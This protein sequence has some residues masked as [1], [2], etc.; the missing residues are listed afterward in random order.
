MWFCSRFALQYTISIA[1]LP[2]CLRC[3]QLV[4]QP[5]VSGMSGS[6]L[7]TT[8]SSKYLP[9]P[10]EVSLATLLPWV[11]NDLKVW[12]STALSLE[13]TTA[14]CLCVGGCGV[15]LGHLFGVGVGPAGL[16]MPDGQAAL[17]GGLTSLPRRIKLTYSFRCS[18]VSP[19]LDSYFQR[20]SGN[21]SL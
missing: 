19:E 12:K 14:I 13:A 16:P 11:R 6:A 21:H 5:V 8:C 20:H 3:R 2:N 10:L 17:G 4:R 1:L 15:R 9:T 18:L 7:R